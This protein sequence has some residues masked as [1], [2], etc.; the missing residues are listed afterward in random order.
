ML[1]KIKIT[2]TK[3]K[4][5]LTGITQ[6][7]QMFYFHWGPEKNLNNKKNKKGVS[8]SLKDIKTVCRQ[9]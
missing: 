6:N 8:K 7:K 1:T 3:R 4:N 5:Y 9:E 2:I